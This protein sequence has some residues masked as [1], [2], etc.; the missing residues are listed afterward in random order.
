MTLGC[1]N[2]KLYGLSNKACEE[3]FAHLCCASDSFLRKFTSLKELTIANNCDIT[4]ETL[5]ML[6]NLEKLHISLDSAKKGFTTL[7]CLTN[8]KKL[9]IGNP[10]STGSCISFE[11]LAQLTNLVSLNIPQLP[12]PPPE[13]DEGLILPNLKSLVLTTDINMS[14]WSQWTNLTKLDMDETE[15]TEEALLK[16]T[17]LVS[18]ELHPE[19][20]TNRVILS[21]TNLTSVSFGENLNENVLFSLTG[22]KQLSIYSDDCP[23]CVSKLTQ[24]ERL[25][26]QLCAMEPGLLCDLSKLTRLDNV[27]AK[28]VNDQSELPIS[29]K[30]LNIA[31]A[32]N[33][34]GVQ[35]VSNLTNLTF[36][37]VRGSSIKGEGFSQLTNLTI[38]EVSTNKYITPEEISKLTNLTELEHRTLEIPDSCIVSLPKLTRVVRKQGIKT[39][40]GRFDLTEQIIY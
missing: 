12:P 23:T 28:H 2:K 8:L 21:L 36:L 35:E 1:V 7:S 15:I 5:A 20:L 27:L 33:A 11:S 16:L 31:A 6:T 25:N 18:L 17:N 29:L 22:L 4:D 3:R 37:H 10:F 39:T 24:L 32:E 19:Y 14:D 40:P 13:N 30:S 26:L 34:R 9:F 38:L